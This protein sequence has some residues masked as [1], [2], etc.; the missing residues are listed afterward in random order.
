[1]APIAC[2]P[3]PEPPLTSIADIPEPYVANAESGKAFDELALAAASVEEVAPED[4]GRIYFT[5]GQKAAARRAMR[6]GFARTWDAMR[7]PVEFEFVPSAPFEPRP[8]R[9][10]WRLLGREFA[11]RIEDAVKAGEF[12]AAV[13][14]AIRGTRFGFSLAGGSVSDASLGFQIVSD[15]RRALAPS[16]GNLSAAQLRRLADGIAG[17]LAGRPPVQQTLDNEI[18][19]MMVTAQALQDAYLSGELDRFRE[20]WG[21]LAEPGLRILKEIRESRRGE[22]AFFAELQVKITESTEAVRDQLAQAARDRELPEWREK[23]LK[24]KAF[25]LMISDTAWPLLALNDAAEARTR[26]L[27]LEAMILLSVK[28]SGRAPATLD[29]LPAALNLDPYSGLPFVYRADGPD[30]E[31]YSVGPNGLDDGGETDESFSEP[32]LRLETS[33]V[34]P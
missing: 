32:D 20:R 19:Q 24:A 21:R 1:M 34:L 11:W 4:I 28:E 10:G 15:V 22:A 31:L 18:E 8:F 7:R 27:A 13:E 12:D 17:C 26:L 16:L 6:T 2:R 30:F 25:H 23:D 29:D 5:P 3:A 14:T 9:S 33:P